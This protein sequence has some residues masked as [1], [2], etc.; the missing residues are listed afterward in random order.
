[1]WRC[2]ISI[3]KL[4]HKKSK[5]ETVLSQVKS[6]EN[7]DKLK[8]NNSFYANLLQKQNKKTRMEFPRSH[9]CLKAYQV[10]WFEA[11]YVCQ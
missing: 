7:V 4:A 2:G 11:V 3:A 9:E 8:V 10:L 5:P 1:V 6:E